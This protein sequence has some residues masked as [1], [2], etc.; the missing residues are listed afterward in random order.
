MPPDSVSDA[1]CF[2]DLRYRFESFQNTVSAR[3]DALRRDVTPTNDPLGINDKQRPLR[4]AVFFPVD[5]VLTGH[6]A[7]GL[8]IRQERKVQF[9]VFAECEMA[10]EVVDRYA[11]DLRFKP[12]EFWLQLVVESQLV[13]A[14]RAPICRVEDQDY[15]L[16]SKV[17]E[18]YFFIRGG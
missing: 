18:G 4:H 2:I 14:D 16:P 10:P 9:A 3:I 15:G 17:R 11:Y 12:G 1:E 6:C 13:T 7:F 5:A 8:K